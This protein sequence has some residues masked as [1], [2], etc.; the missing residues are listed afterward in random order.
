MD[1]RERCRRLRSPGPISAL[2]NRLS[3]DSVSN[4]RPCGI[5]HSLPLAV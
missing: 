3:P 5:D 2:E 1:M 4:H